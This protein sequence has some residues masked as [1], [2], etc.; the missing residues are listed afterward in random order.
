MLCA[1]YIF[2]ISLRTPLLIQSLYVN[3]LGRLHNDEKSPRQQASTPAGPAYRWEAELAVMG[4]A[5]H[6][7]AYKWPDT[8]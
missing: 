6:L 3:Y 8:K 5:Q 4:Y 1:L 2:V 7:T